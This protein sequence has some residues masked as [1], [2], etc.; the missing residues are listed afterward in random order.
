MTLATQCLVSELEI[1]YD[2]Q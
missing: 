1:L 2:V